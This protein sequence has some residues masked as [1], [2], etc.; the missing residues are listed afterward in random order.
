MCKGNLTQNCSQEAR[1]EGAGPARKVP[2][3]GPGEA[4]HAALWFPCSDLC[5]KQPLPASSFPPQRTLSSS[6][7]CTCLRAT[8][9]LAA[10]GDSTAVSNKLISAEIKWLFA[11]LLLLSRFSR[12]GLCVTLQTAAHQGPPSLG[13]SRQEHWTGVGC[14]FLLQCMKVKRESEVAQSCPIPSNPMACRP[15]GSSIHGIFQARVLEWGANVFSDW[16]PQTHPKTKFKQ[17][18]NFTPTKT[19]R[20]QHQKWTAIPGLPT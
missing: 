7:P 15:P 12:V 8:R 10:K 13:F 14:H 19:K 1:K 11:L 18:R 6:A 20:R 5:S 9:V 3:C 2:A 17:R 4:P 16:S